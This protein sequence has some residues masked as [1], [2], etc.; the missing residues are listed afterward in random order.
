MLFEWTSN[1]RSN[2]RA[3]DAPS[4]VDDYGTLDELRH[5]DEHLIDADAWSTTTALSPTTPAFRGRS[6]TCWLWWR[7]SA[8]VRKQSP[9]WSRCTAGP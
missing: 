6:P 4:L 7:C 3:I 1:M 8:P 2:P 5:Y 9:C